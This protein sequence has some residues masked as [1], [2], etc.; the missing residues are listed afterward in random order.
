[1]YSYPTHSVAALPYGEDILIFGGTRSGKKGRDERVMTIFHYRSKK[2]IDLENPGVIPP[3]MAC[4]SYLRVKEEI[5][6]GFQENNKEHVWQFD[7]EKWRP[8]F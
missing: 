3:Y 7:G 6:V 2:F 4:R 5:Y 8:K 1:M